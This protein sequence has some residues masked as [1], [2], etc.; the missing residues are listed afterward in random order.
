[1]AQP[2]T[3]EG[4]LGSLSDVQ[5]CAVRHQDG[6]LLVLAGPGSGKTRILTT[7]IA[8]LLHEAEDAPFRVLAL[9]F[10]NRA[11]DEM[12]GRIERMAPEAEHRLFI[13]TFHAF[14]ADVLRQHGQHLGIKTDFRIYSTTEDRAE[15][16][17]LAIASEAGREAGLEAQHG[18]FLPLVDRAKAKLI[19][20]KGVASRF[21]SA[22]R[23]AKFEAFYAA[24]DAALGKAN[25]LDFDSLVFNVYRLFVRFPALARR[26]RSVYR[27][28]CIDEFQ[29]TNL[30]QYETIKAMAGGELR[31][32]FAVADDDQ[33]IYQWNGA[34]HRRLDEFREDFE[35]EIVQ[36]PTNFRCPPEV[37]TCANRLIAHNL[38]RN[39]IKRPLVAEREST[40]SPSVVEVL[41]FG[42]AEDET[43]GIAEHIERHRGDALAQTAVLARV[44]RLL[45]PIGEGIILDSNHS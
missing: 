3:L 32:V 35:A 33:I 43:Q 1:M 8:R 38:L 41:S 4:A 22:G 14:S 2:A 13:G 37:V 15:I 7:R 30:A 20:S 29:D 16:G 39:P 31:N 36:V 28:C 21:R 5:R 11:A 6:A 44:R 23:G 10:T 27:Y 18:S 19:P 17:S 40:G 9:T 45:A 24:Y 34:D 26:Y 12:R 25:A 42:T